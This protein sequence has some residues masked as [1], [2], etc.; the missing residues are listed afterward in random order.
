MRKKTCA[1]TKDS[2]FAY[3]YKVI[4][5]HSNKQICF[6]FPFEQINRCNFSNKKSTFT[7][8]NWSLGTLLT[9]II[10]KLTVSKRTY[11]EA[12]EL[13]KTYTKRFFYDIMIH[14]KFH[15][16]MFTI[17]PNQSTKNTKKA[18]WR[19]MWATKYKKLKL[20]CF[21]QSVETK[22]MFSSN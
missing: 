17:V 6:S 7:V 14:L 21:V 18:W 12:R 10:T 19:R 13:N 11:G 2:L 16:S 22:S 4:Q 5:K 3:G 9:L 8:D 20:T 1:S 15:K